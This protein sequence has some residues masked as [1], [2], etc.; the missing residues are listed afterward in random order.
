MILILREYHIFIIRVIIIE[1][2]ID[3]KW[4]I[5]SVDINELNSIFIR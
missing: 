1:D 5:Q 2:I 4:D 3:R